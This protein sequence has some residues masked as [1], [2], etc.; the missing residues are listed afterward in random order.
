MQSTPKSIPMP[1]DIPVAMH[2]EMAKIP[3]NQELTLTDKQQQK[4]KQKAKKYHL[5]TCPRQTLIATLCCQFWFWAIFAR[6]T[7]H[8][9]HWKFQFTWTQTSKLTH[10]IAAAFSPASSSSVSVSI[11]VEALKWLWQRLTLPQLTNRL[12]DQSEDQ[13]IKPIAWSLV[14][15]ITPTLS[16]T[17]DCWQ[18]SAHLHVAGRQAS[19]TASSQPP[20]TNSNCYRLATF[21]ATTH[22][23]YQHS[24]GGVI[25]QQVHVSENNNHMQQATR[26]ARI[27]CI[28]SCGALGICLW[29]QTNVR[30]YRLYAT[31]FR[32]QHIT[33]HLGQPHSR[34]AWSFCGGRV[35]VVVSSR[36]LPWHMYEY[37]LCNQ[38]PFIASLVCPLFYLPFWLSRD[39]VLRGHVC[40]L[41]GQDAP[42]TSYAPHFRFN[43]RIF[44]TSP[45]AA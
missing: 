42:Y 28:L 35:I 41:F 32:T 1:V 30:C 20:T 37:R 7:T 43:L 44:A 34:S 15:S 13:L 6:H 31:S 9:G 19:P 16:S 26:N 3:S 38:R 2:V 27:K 8:N 22:T 29:S 10:E 39:F 14:R 36:H 12:T 23:A 24:N 33:T 45:S 11:S 25:A 21:S 40:G 4:Q 17:S 5:H 18:L